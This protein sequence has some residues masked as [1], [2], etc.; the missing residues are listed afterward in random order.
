VASPAAAKK[1]A[2]K[3]PN[4]PKK[5]STAVETTG[6]LFD[7]GKQ[8][9]PPT[10]QKHWPR[11]FSPWER[12][13]GRIL[14]SGPCCEDSRRR[15]PTSSPPSPTSIDRRSETAWRFP[16]TSGLPTPT[17]LQQPWRGTMPYLEGL[18]L[19]AI[20]DGMADAG[21][22]FIVVGGA[23]AVMLGAPVTTLDVHVVH[24][25]SPRIL[26]ACSRGC[27][28]SMRTTA[29]ISPTGSSRQP[30]ISCRG[31]GTSTFRPTSE[32]WIC[33]ANSLRAR[34]MNRSFRIRW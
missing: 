14:S 31:A 6:N 28:P 1:S 3:T 24:Q 11:T 33:S 4:K 27:Q 19:G 9:T 13:F 7:R 15:I 10:T 22:D 30:R 32:S 29:S 5:I 18:G 16:Q 8:S 21:I 20:L 17:P 25:R 2:D 26:R 23:A 34:A 12:P